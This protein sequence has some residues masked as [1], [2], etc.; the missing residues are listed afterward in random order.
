[1]I[2]SRAIAA[3]EV[4]A[5]A[6]RTALPAVAVVAVLYALLL[7]ALNIM[8]AIGDRFSTVTGGVERI[9][10]VAMWDGP[11]VAPLLLGAFMIIL[12]YELWLRK[13]A[14]LLVL[15]GFIVS[16]ALVD[17]I[18]GMSRGA[19]AATVI[20]AM[21]LALAFKQFPGRPDPRALKKLRVAA[22]ALAAVFFT[23]GVLGL[24]LMRASLGIHSFNMYRLAYRTIAVAVGDSGLHFAGSALAF[25]GSLTALATGGIFLIVYLLFR[26][27]RESADHP[28][29]LRERAHHLVEDYGSDSLAYF[30]TRSDKSFFFDGDD[31]FL[32]YKVVGDVA[33]ISGDPVGPPERIPQIMEA[34]NGYCLSRGWRLAV[35]GASGTLVPLY[36]EVG[37]RGFSLGEEAIVEVG[38][39][40]L[41][42]RQ[43]RKLRQS[44]NKLARAGYSM[45]FMYNA[46]IPAHMKHELARISVDWRGGKQETGF[47]MGL[48]RLMSAEDPDCLLAVA[49]DPEMK[50]VGFLHFV[51]MYPRL[52]YSLDVHRSMIGSPGALSEFMI[53]NTAQFLRAEGYRQMSLHFLAFCEHYR[54][55]RETPGNPLW[56]GFAKLLDRFLPV[57]SAYQFDR[58]FNPSWKKRYLLH[59]GIADLVLVGIAATVAESAL[60]VT[61]PSDRKSKQDQAA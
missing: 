40:S 7:G 55:D 42:G 25:K 46:S 48:G 58:K 43:M 8:Q 60:S 1:M 30:N 4:A 31:C 18:R 5:R 36:Q 32:A 33:V 21:C 39:F 13:R 10:H 6:L 41:E 12:A 47:S 24:Y 16:Q 38:G 9:T 34:F 56:R 49:Y 57:V 53:A 20:F 52:G 61:R 28:L 17:S 50:P 3:G 26:P 35:I 2:R 22:P 11:A 29:E 54:D 44:V 45:E 59:V 37:L 15:C 23:Y 27:Y 14:A 51:P 19:L